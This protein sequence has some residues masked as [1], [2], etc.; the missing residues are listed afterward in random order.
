MPLPNEW[1]KEYAFRGLSE[2]EW[3]EF[4]AENDVGDEL[5]CECQDCETF[6]LNGYHRC[7]CGNRRVYLYSDHGY[8]RTELS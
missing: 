5:H 2:E 4:S 3:E 7:Q 1:Y 8:I 6:E